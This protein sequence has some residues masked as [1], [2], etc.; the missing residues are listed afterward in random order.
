MAGKKQ[1]LDIAKLV[2]D[3]TRSGLPGVP[4]VP[5]PVK[6]DPGFRNI[7]PAVAAER[8]ASRDVQLKR[9]LKE[10]RYEAISA[11]E[12][13]PQFQEEQFGKNL[14]W[15]WITPDPSIAMTASGLRQMQ[16]RGLGLPAATRQQA[17]DQVLAVRVKA[18]HRPLYQEFVDQL[19]MAKLSVDAGRMSERTRKQNL[20]NYAYNAMIKTFLPMEAAGIPREWTGAVSRALPEE[21]YPSNK[22]YV[23]YVRQVSIAMRNMDNGQRKLFLSQLKDWRGPVNQLAELVFSTPRRRVKEYNRAL[24]FGAEPATPK[25]PTQ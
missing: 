9:H 8:Q 14:D 3:T 15:G 10:K 5:N 6:M 18:G 2:A 23:S 21:M 12:N 22:N 7:N 4:Q 25:G 1:F 17:L 19:N 11:F 13:D 20:P 24:G 16:A